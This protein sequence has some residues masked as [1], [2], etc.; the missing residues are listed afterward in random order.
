MNLPP[1]LQPGAAAQILDATGTVSPARILPGVSNDLTFSLPLPAGFTVSA[2][3]SWMV[4]LPP[5]FTLPDP[6]SGRSVSFFGL[7]PYSYNAVNNPPST[8]GPFTAPIDGSPAGTIWVWSTVNNSPTYSG[9]TLQFILQKVLN[10]TATG[11]TASFAVR[12]GGTNSTNCIF[13][14]PGITISDS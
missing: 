4:T 11:A 10:P 1:M 3:S 9:I 12:I 14:V 5:G 7:A 13:T 2:T 8:L 6:S